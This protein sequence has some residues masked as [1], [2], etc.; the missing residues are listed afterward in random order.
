VTID[1]DTFDVGPTPPPWTLPGAQPS[2]DSLSDDGTTILSWTRDISDQVWIAADTTIMEGR[3]LLGRPRLV[4]SEVRWFN[5][6]Y[7]AP[8]FLQVIVGI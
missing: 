3:R 2:W 8:E 1:P 6:K 4:R 7:R 5:P